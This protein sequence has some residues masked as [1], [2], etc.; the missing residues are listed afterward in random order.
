MATAAMPAGN[1]VGSTAGS[2][3]Q[4]PQVP[5]E[6]V[7]GTGVED[8]LVRYVTEIGHGPGSAEQLRAFVA[9]RGGR[10]T[11]SL[12][13]Q[14]MAMQHQGFGREPATA[15]SRSVSDARGIEQEP[16]PGFS[17]QQQPFA[18]RRLRPNP[19]PPRLRHWQGREAERDS[20]MLDWAGVPP[21]GAEVRSIGTDPWSAPARRILGTGASSHRPHPSTSSMPSAASSSSVGESLPTLVDRVGAL[22]E[23]LETRARGPAL[24]EALRES[25]AQPLHEGRVGPRGVRQAEVTMRTILEAIRAAEMHAVAQSEAAARRLQDRLQVAV[26]EDTTECS[27]CLDTGDMPSWRSLPCGHS[28][29]EKCLLEWARRARHRTCP[30]CRLDLDDAGNA[31]ILEGVGATPQV[32]SARGEEPHT[33]QRP[34]AAPLQLHALAE[35]ISPSS[36][37]TS[38]SSTPGWQPVASV[39]GLMMDDWITAFAGAFAERTR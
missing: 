23:F 39:G 10:L 3:E 1:W 29:H 38:P 20:L 25:Q 9:H 5:Q 11:Y 21:E 27:I 7:A 36:V 26:V 16:R 33:P 19:P 6:G 34:V 4:D 13:R 14:A 12:A 32:T 30:L 18:T 2:E 37:E 28:F 22:R 31:G 8:W 17:P 15:H 24:A 35:G